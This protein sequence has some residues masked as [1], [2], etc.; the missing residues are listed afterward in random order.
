MRCEPFKIDVDGLDDG[1]KESPIETEELDNT[2]PE[3]DT[4]GGAID[5]L[6]PQVP[7]IER[8]RGQNLEAQ[9]MTGLLKQMIQASTPLKMSQ[10]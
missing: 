9:K 7:M 5:K 6:K 4:K 3:L 10:A 8:T 2:D 1:T